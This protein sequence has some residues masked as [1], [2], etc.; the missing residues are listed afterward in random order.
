MISILKTTAKRSVGIVRRMLNSAPSSR[1]MILMYHRVSTTRHDPWGLTVSPGNFVEQV[2]MIVRTRRV[3]SLREFF[4]RFRS[5]TLPF[6]AVAIT[7]DDGYAD[8]FHV[9]APLLK[10]FDAPAT[11]FITTGYLADPSSGGMS[12]IDCC[13]CFHSCH[14]NSISPLTGKHRPFG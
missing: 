2:E 3:M 6:G 7:F 1:P 4:Q 13:Y 11:L 10:K 5:R 9:A 8:N 14:P 12:Q